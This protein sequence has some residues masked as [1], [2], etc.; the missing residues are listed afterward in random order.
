MKQVEILL[1]TNIYLRFA[2]SHHPLLPGPYIT[3][4]TEYR[5]YIIP[6]IQVEYDKSQKIQDNFSWFTQRRFWNNRESNY[7]DISSIAKSDLDWHLGYFRNCS[8]GNASKVDLKL[9]AIGEILEIDIATDEETMDEIA[10][11][12]LEIDIYD[13]LDIFQILLDSG[14]TMEKLISTVHYLE[15]VDDLPYPN[16]KKDFEFH[17]GVTL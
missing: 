14:E 12:L 2:R 9:L 3:P 6:E 4:K 7:Y 8:T 1:D 17:F 13:S 16:F 11:E 10:A 5:F 15:H